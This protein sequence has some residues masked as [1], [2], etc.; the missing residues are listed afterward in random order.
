MRPCLALLVSLTLLIAPNFSAAQVSSSTTT[1]HPTYTPRPATSTPASPKLKAIPSTL[2]QCE[3]DQCT[4]GGGGA[5]WIFDGLRGQAAWHFGAVANLSVQSFDGR[6]IVINR[7]DPP[8]TYSSRWAGKDGYFRAVYRGTFH[9][10]RVDGTVVWNGNW[11]HPGTWYAVAP[12]VLCDPMQQCP[13]DM[14]QLIQLGKNAVNA[15]L[16]R[17]ALIAFFAGARQGNSDAQA[18]AG[19]MLLDGKGASPHYALAYQLLQQSAEQNNY[20][21]EVGLAKMY[22]QGLVPGKPK[23]PERAAFWKNRAQQR[24]QEMRAQAAQQQ[25]MQQAQAAMGLF[26]FGALAAIIVGA[27]DYDTD[28]AFGDT[29]D[30]IRTVNDCIELYQQAQRTERLLSQ[31]AQ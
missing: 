21:G 19:W 6:N 18:Y 15:G 17:A 9:G 11:Q 16:Y 20:N 31:P 5:I 28:D 30:A 23:D 14:G 25:Q 27:S 12:E 8:G 3:Q 2:L 26:A 13:L 10:N 7:A 22:E 4:R 29:V 24:E 1:S